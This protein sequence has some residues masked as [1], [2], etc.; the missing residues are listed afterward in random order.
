MIADFLVYVLIC[1]QAAYFKG[2]N[3]IKRPGSDH[4]TADVP[5]LLKYDYFLDY[6]KVW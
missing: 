3:P 5:N 2:F 6:I 1:L 4:D